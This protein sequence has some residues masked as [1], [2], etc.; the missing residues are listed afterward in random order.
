MRTERKHAEEVLLKTQQGLSEAQRIAHLGNWDWNI[1]TNELLWSD[2]GYRIF[3]V[4]PQEFGATYDAFLSSVHPDDREFVKKSVDEA[5]YK[6]KNYNIDHRIVLPDGSERIV[7]EQG[8]VRFEDHGKPIHMIG[9]IHDIT[10]RKKAEIEKREAEERHRTLV[11]H[12]YDIIAETSDAGKFLYVNPTFE[13][14]L[15]YKSEEVLNTIIFDYV[16]EEDK[17][18]V[19]VKFK[20]ALRKFSG[21]NGE[22]RFRH[23]DGSW[24]WLES[25]GSPFQTAAGEIRAAISSRD[26]TERKRAEEDL[27]NAFSEIELLKDRLEKENIYLKKEIE[28]TYSHADIIGES[29]AIKLALNKIEQVADTDS[30][31][32]LTGE[33][34]TGKERF[35]ERIHNLSRHS[36]RTM[37]KVNCAA[38]P[39][40]LIESELFGHEK[41]A[42]TGA[43][44]KSMGRFEMA[45]DSTIFLDEVGELP[46]E[47]QSKLL[48][49]LQE[50]EFQRVGSSDTTKVNVRVIAASNNDLLDAVNAGKFRDDLYYRLN[51]FPINIPPLR[52]RKEDI[53]DLLWFFIS[54]FEEEMGKTIKN[55][56]RKDMENLINYPWPGNIRQLRNIIERAMIISSGPDLEIEMPGI[57][58]ERAPLEI[59]EMDEVERNHISHILNLTDWRIRGKAGAA[60]I[61]GLKPTT[62]E[63]R[64]KK[65]AIVRGH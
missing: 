2:E 49:V 32:L 59:K 28:L 8:E 22:Y 7:H 23:K 11:E 62:L 24:R 30:T 43:V 48:R 40:H 26:I 57:S 20:K 65:L 45:D 63:S 25:I 31:V 44:S 3:G 56:S 33:T 29:K 37:V 61:L 52:E 41:G 12:S 16:H 15:G 27:K 1:Q 54:E 21:E 4:K 60:E 9:T 13:E 55:I 34:G 51:V 38:L 35:A 19:K 14:L 47:L 58:S 46:L 6:R 18:I 17:R 5:V 53:T 36:G 39:P 50:G 10:E 64:I 42:Y